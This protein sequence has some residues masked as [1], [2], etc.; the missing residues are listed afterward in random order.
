MVTN[1]NRATVNTAKRYQP[2]VKNDTADNL[3]QK[4]RKKETI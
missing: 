1:K 4:D 2:S 3:L